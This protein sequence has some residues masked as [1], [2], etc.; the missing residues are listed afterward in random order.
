MSLPPAGYAPEH[1]PS[2]PT[3]APAHGSKV[4]LNMQGLKTLMTNMHT[5]TG[6]ERELFALLALV[7]VLYAGM[8]FLFAGDLSLPSSTRTSSSSHN[9]GVTAAKSSRRYAEELHTLLTAQ[10]RWLT[11]SGLHVLGSSIMV[12]W[13]Y[14]FHSHGDDGYESANG[15]ED[16]SILAGLRL[17]PN[18]VTFTITLI[19]MLF[20]GYL[21]TVLKDE[22]REVGK[23]LAMRR[24]AEDDEME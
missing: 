11:L 15:A 9:N 5:T 17:L 10:S 4:S 23:F 1:P 20:W 22:G 6:S 3:P 21:W 24:A 7:L 2:A 16:T 12:A 8:M 13:I 14:A 18:R 19:D